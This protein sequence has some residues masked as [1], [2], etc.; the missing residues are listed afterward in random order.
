MWLLPLRSSLRV[1]SVYLIFSDV[2]YYIYLHLP[3]PSSFT[4]NQFFWLPFNFSSILFFS[5]ILVRV[6]V[7]LV[8]SIIFLDWNGV[9]PFST[10]IYFS[11]DLV[12][13]YF[14][15]NLLSSL[16]FFCQSLTSVLVLKLKMQFA[17]PVLSWF[18]SASL[19]SRLTESISLFLLSLM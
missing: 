8:F 19:S 5:R 17:M 10:A 12:W 6:L 11:L 1:V 16:G 7:V 18:L 13:I 4:T 14:F 3:P 15:I 9:V 2:F